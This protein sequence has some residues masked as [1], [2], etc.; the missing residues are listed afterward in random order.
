[1]ALLGG[2]VICGPAGNDNCPIYVGNLPPDIQSKHSEDVF[3]KYS[4]IR[5][6]DFKNRHG[7]ELVSS[8]LPSSNLSNQCCFL[9]ACS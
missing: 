2:G 9:L 3:Y 6:I 5:D 8:R 4:A 7:G 1:M